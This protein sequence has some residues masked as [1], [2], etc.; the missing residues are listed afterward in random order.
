MADPTV[1]ALAARLDALTADLLQLRQ[2]L[3]AGV[4]VPDMASQSGKYL[5]TDGTMPG[6]GAL[7]IS[8]IGVAAP[9]TSTGGASPVIGHANSGVAAGTY[10][11]ATVTCDARGHI[12]GIVAGSA[13]VTSVGAAAPLSSSGG[14][15]PSISLTGTVPVANGGTGATTVANART[16]LGLGTAAV[17]NTGTAGAVVPLLTGSNTWSASQAITGGLTVSGTGNGLNITDRTTGG[18]WSW[19]ATGGVTYLWL[20]TAGNVLSLSAAGVLGV[21]GLSL[22]DTTAQYVRG[23]GTLATLPASGSG[24]VTSVTAG[25]GMNFVTFT[26]AGTITLGVPSTCTAAT[27]NGASGT[28]HTHAITG[29]MPTT[30]GTFTGAIT[31]P[32]VTDSSDAA[33]KRDVRDLRDGLAIVRALMPRRF[34][35]VLTELDEVGFVAQEVRDVLPEI[36]STDDDGRLAVAYQ[37]LTAPIIAALHELDARI[38][39][40]ESR[41]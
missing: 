31:A 8:A 18:T 15:T 37:R 32:G 14:A 27:G 19:Y 22:P 39:R 40:L 34:W 35:N 38:K 28:T 1:T 13:G 33:Y 20:N 17:Q 6:W 29:F 30:G 7:P 36:V 5:T 12:T 23:D 10:A 11:L 41:A 2:Q 16:S 25:A 9:I 3:S 26:T 21:A 4:G 24:T